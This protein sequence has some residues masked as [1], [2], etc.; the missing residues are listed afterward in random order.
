MRHGVTRKKKHKQIKAYRKSVQKESTVKKC[1]LI[2]ELKLFRSQ[3]KGKHSIGRDYQSLTVRGKKPL[4]QAFI[5]YNFLCTRFC[6]CE[7]VLG[8]CLCA[9][10]IVQVKEQTCTLLVITYGSRNYTKL[11]LKPLAVKSGL[12]I[13]VLY[14]APFLQII[15]FQFT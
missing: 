9:W 15:L 1:L 8:P 2:L 14:I 3:V 11:V 13:S 5:N 12:S 6:A 10:K 7:D 4:T